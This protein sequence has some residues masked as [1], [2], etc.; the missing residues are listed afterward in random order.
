LKN[1][2]RRIHLMRIKRYIAM[3]ICILMLGCATVPVKDTP[4]ITTVPIV[5]EKV[6][7]EIE[8]SVY[9]LHA[10][11]NF[12]KRKPDMLERCSIVVR[13]THL[14]GK[15]NAWRMSGFT[16]GD[17]IVLYGRNAVVVSEFP[18]KHN[19][20]ESVYRWFRG[21]ARMYIHTK[22]G[23]PVDRMRII[24]N[25]TFTLTTLRV[26]VHNTKPVLEGKET[27]HKRPEKPESDIFISALK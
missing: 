19:D 27:T 11:F 3:F 7:T 6:S 25:D 24:D 9:R 21:K 13:I 1:T 18:C 5:P 14:P 22:K 8:Y 16:E 12:V 2:W 20:P 10:Y 15:R 4:E 17:F 23:W 26:S